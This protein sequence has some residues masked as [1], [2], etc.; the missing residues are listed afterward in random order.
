MADYVMYTIGIMFALVNAAMGGASFVF[1]KM[2][3]LEAESKMD[4]DGYN[5]NEETSTGSC[6]L[7]P[8]GN[9][10]AD[11]DAKDDDESPLGSE[12]GSKKGVPIKYFMKTWNWWLFFLLT[13][14]GESAGVIAYN[15]APAMLVAP[16]GCLAIVTTC[17]CSWYYLGETLTL[18]KRIGILLSLL[19]CAIV[20]VNTHPM[21]NMKT[22]NR[23]V[24]DHI[25][26]A[27][28]LCYALINFI[29]IVITFVFRRHHVLCRVAFTSLCSA[30][31]NL[32]CKTVG[33]AVKSV[34][35][36][37]TDGKFLIDPYFWIM[38]AVMVVSATAYMIQITKALGASDTINITI[39]IF[40]VANCASVVLANSMLFQEY[41]GLTITNLVSLACAF[42]VATIGVFN[43]YRL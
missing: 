9:D 35:S 25:K 7:W 6:R 11:A 38:F 34:F 36:G 18:S 42:T 21:H 28:F 2:S 12:T 39:P 1:N 37:D 15:L 16:L 27:P 14:L 23:F 41:H 29:G 8:S 30:F 20:V 26:K 17:I 32:G 31:I 22:F 19:G 4:E 24:H 10:T 40:Y 13:L 43:I 5:N 3:T 33:V